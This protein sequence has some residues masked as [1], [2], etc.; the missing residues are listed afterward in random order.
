MKR[1][2]LKILYEDKCLLV[3]YKD[4]GIPTIK[5]E[6]YKNN[7]YSE[8]YDYLHKKNQRIFNNTRTRK[9]TKKMKKAFLFLH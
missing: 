4:Y 5:S 9:L 3:V 2:K 8:V 1:N 7:L 6:K